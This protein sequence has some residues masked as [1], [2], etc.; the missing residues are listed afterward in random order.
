MGVGCS[1]GGGT[2]RQSNGR[3][4][5]RATCV[6]LQGPAALF[7]GGARQ[8]RLGG[9]G[10]GVVN[11]MKMNGSPPSPFYKSVGQLKGLQKPKSHRCPILLLQRIY[12][13][14]WIPSADKIK[15]NNSISVN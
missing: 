5:A 3:L 11:G 14:N 7:V 9:G 12:C 1:G 8:G 6:Q 10:G 4:R 13:R 15:K 2:G